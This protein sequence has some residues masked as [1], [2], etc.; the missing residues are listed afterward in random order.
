MSDGVTFALSGAKRSSVAAAKSILQRA[1]QPDDPG[2]ARRIGEIADWRH[3]YAPIFTAVTRLEAS[4]PETAV[5]LAERG[6]AAT[7]E[8]M[9]FATD[10][11][12]QPLSRALEVDTP[13]F[14]TVEVAGGHRG[15]RS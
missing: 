2:L 9:C 13:A 4:S 1:V 3:D 12:E 8:V 10:D 6:L 14:A 11:G 5:R 15:R 7:G